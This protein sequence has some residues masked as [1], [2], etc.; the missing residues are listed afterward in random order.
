MKIKY[1]YILYIMGIL[2]TL[3]NFGKKHIGKFI[4]KI[5]EYIG[6]FLGKKLKEKGLETLS[7]VVSDSVKRIGRS[8]NMDELRNTGKHIVSENVGR[9]LERVNPFLRSRLGIDGRT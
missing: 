5:G 4:P 6:D 1:K 3:L 9:G 8:R 7:D 2:Q